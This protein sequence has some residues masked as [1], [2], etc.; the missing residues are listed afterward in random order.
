MSNVKI[1]CQENCCDIYTQLENATPAERTEIVLELIERH[2]ERLLLLP[3]IN[4]RGANL[5]GVDLSCSALKAKLAQQGRKS[6]PWW[7][8]ERQGAYLRGAQLEGAWL[9]D[10]RFTGA[11]LGG[12]QLDGAYLRD[13]Q[14]QKADLGGAEL[15]DLNLFSCNLAHIFVYSAHL[16]HTRLRWE[17]LG[18]A[19]GEELRANASTS[20]QPRVRAELYT[21]AQYGY[22][23]LKRNFGDQGFYQDANQAYRKERRMEKLA[24]YHR[25]RASVSDRAWREAIRSWWK[26]FF[27]E[28][29]E[30]LCDYGEGF[31]HVIAWM[32][33]LLF[34]V[35]PVL[36]KLAGGLHWTVTNQGIY[37]ELKTHWARFWYSYFQYLLYTLD[38][39]TTAKFSPLE[40]A[41]DAVR[42]LSGLLSMAGIFLT[43]L[44][45]FVAGNRIRRS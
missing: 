38:T 42:L 12:A 36:I 32:I 45:G 15:R 19:I 25:M 35:G 41:T 2:T 40:P 22:L 17:Q 4:G 3:E 30:I 23:I 31:W 8:E 6:A 13:T 33:G 21:R 37:A 18:G 16:D 44:F 11:Y 20:G 14:F 28:V 34:L 43:G 24:A 27:D 7:D 9:W 10:A 1:S 29:A 39:L 5:I 26:A